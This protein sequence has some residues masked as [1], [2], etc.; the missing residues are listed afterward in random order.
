MKLCFPVQTNNAMESLVYNHFGSAPDFLI[1]DT[2][3]GSV[4]TVGNRD[5]HHEHGACNP[6]MALNGEDV[7]AVIVGGIGGGA[8]NKLNQKGIKVF[9]AAKPTI[10]ENTELYK[11][12]ELQQFSLQHTCSG[13]GHAHG[14]SH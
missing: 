1:V 10:R 11:T 4:T 8:I 9:R 5:L 7:D 12:G 2:E 14:C 13:H 3:T 6:V